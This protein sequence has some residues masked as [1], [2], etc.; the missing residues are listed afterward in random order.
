MIVA[1]DKRRI[2]RRKWDVD[3]AQRYGNMKSYVDF[4]TCS[5]AKNAC[6]PCLPYLYVVLTTPLPSASQHGQR[7]QHRRI[8]APG[9]PSPLTPSPTAPPPPPSSLSSSSPVVDLARDVISLTHNGLLV[10][11]IAFDDVVGLCG[12]LVVKYAVADIAIPSRLS[13]SS[14]VDDAWHR[15]LLFPVIYDVACRRAHEL[16]GMLSFERNVVSLDSCRASPNIV[17][18]GALIR[19]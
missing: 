12:F 5:P 15:L 11:G 8:D 3:A 18:S 9:F 4:S 16:A 6:Q 13:P 17:A 10:G 2:I 1:A 7:Q 14:V 19:S